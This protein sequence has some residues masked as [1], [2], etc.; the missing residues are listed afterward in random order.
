M[1]F[2]ASAFQPLCATAAW[3]AT[4]S[5]VAGATSTSGSTG[6]LLSYPYDVTFDGYRNMYV[7]DQNNHR[8]QRFRPGIRSIMNINSLQICFLFLGS[9]TG[10]TVAGFNLGSGVGRSE[11]YYPGAI[12]V[13]SSGLMYILDTYNCRVLTWKVGEPIG[14]VV[15]NG[16]GCSSAYTNIGRSYGLFV[17]SQT[18]I[19]V[20]ENVYHRVTLWYNGNNTA[21]TLV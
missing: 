21:G 17:D 10:T 5:V 9:N 13:D 16:R 20:S 6:T 2:L 19:Y 12:Q 1:N 8:I 4:F 7:V 15:V 3:N 11:L 18:N 14:T